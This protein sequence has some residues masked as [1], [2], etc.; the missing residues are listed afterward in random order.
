MGM[1]S[2]IGLMTLPGEKHFLIIQ[3]GGAGGVCSREGAKNTQWG[4]MEV[5]GL[6]RVGDTSYIS[7]L[8]IGSG[9]GG[10]GPREVESYQHLL[11]LLRRGAGR[12][13]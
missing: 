2:S 12:Q 6:L 11:G 3:V 5:V 7:C 1:G 10:K 9:L 4:W 13:V 8:G